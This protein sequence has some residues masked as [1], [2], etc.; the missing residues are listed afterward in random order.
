MIA[1]SVGKMKP[2]KSAKKGTKQM[3]NADAEI[4]TGIEAAGAKKKRQRSGEKDTKRKRNA[5]KMKPLRNAERDTK[6]KMN[7]GVGAAGARMKRPKSGKRDTKMTMNADAEKRRKE[8]RKTG[9]KRNAKRNDKRRRKNEEKRPK[10]RNRRGLTCESP[11][12]L[13][14]K[15]SADRSCNSTGA[16]CVA[17]TREN[18]L[19]SIRLGRK[20]TRAKIPLFINAL[21]GRRVQNGVSRLS[22][23]NPVLVTNLTCSRSLIT[24]IHWRCKSM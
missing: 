2:R 12:V 3:M 1:R 7:V 4:E 14:S 15:R 10:K 23:R 21:I 18:S 8:K 19:I 20:S 22:P 5:G 6:K 9:T 24:P 16:I 11:V 13:E 17:S